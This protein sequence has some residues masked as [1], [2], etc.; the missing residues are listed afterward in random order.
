MQNIKHRLAILYKTAKVYISDAKHYVRHSLLSGYQDSEE[1]FLRM[2]TLRAHVVEKGLTMP[3]MRLN[4]GEENILLL[5]DLCFEYMDKKYDTKRTMFLE[6]VRVLFEYENV[7]AQRGVPVHARIEEGILRLKAV[8]PD[9]VAGEQPEMHA[10]ELFKRG[11]FAYIARHRRSVRHFAGHI[12]PSDIVRAVDLA[13][14]APSACN[15]QPVKVHIVPRGAQFDRL[16][17]LQ[18]G[19]RGFG[20]DA[21]Y[22]L[23]VTV[24]EAGY[25][26]IAERNAMYVDGGIFIMNLLYS[27]QYYAIASCTLNC[28]FLPEEEKTLAS[29]L[30]TEDVA[31]AMIAIGSCPETFKVARS[32]R[33]PL[34]E[35]I[36]NQSAR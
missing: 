7:H 23:V 22:L 25:N 1:K 12:D 31:V 33:I 6:A 34:D 9:L 17:Q 19:N 3:N 26:G 8:F 32:S 11:D 16:L 10:A 15:R 35:I 13:R 21:E 18:H 29:I 4:F 14:T 24:T 36:I 28:S 20:S 30:Q 5:L 2:I 27:L